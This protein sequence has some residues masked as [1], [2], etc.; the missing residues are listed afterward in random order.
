MVCHWLFWELS[1]NKP[2]INAFPELCRGIVAITPWSLWCFINKQ[3]L[4]T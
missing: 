3:T 4:G 2:M 1:C